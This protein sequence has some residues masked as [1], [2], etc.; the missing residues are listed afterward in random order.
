MKELYIGLRAILKES[1]S[2]FTRDALTGR[3]SFSLLDSFFYF[4][5]PLLI[6]IS[7]FFFDLPINKALN[8][9]IVGVLTIFVALSFQVVFIATDKFSSRIAQLREKK[10]NEDEKVP[11]FDDEKNYLKRIG[12]YSRQFVR[13]LI[14]LILFSVLIIICSLALILI[15]NHIVNVAVSSI[16][17]P[18][19]YIWLL[20][21]LKMIV[22]IYNLQ[23]DDIKQNY[24]LLR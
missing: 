18:A 14:L 13:Q 20:L 9:A 10:H 23:M 7:T 6:L 17:L 12:N 24:S 15:E 11:V 19:F 4:M 5:L 2:V 22:S 3:L 1:M 16:M 21:L 8:E